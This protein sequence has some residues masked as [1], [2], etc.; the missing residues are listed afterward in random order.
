MTW[1]RILGLFVLFLITG[2][3]CDDHDFVPL[4][5]ADPGGAAGAPAATAVSLELTPPELSLAAGTSAEV[6]ATLVS[7]DGTTS[8]ATSNASWTSSEPAV[9][10]VD[11][12]TVV[13]VKKGSAEITVSS[14]G[15]TS[16]L[17]VT[18]TDAALVT[19]SITPQSPS[20]AKGLEKQLT[21]TGVFT[22]HTTQ[23]LTKQVT[24]SSDA[25]KVATVN[26]KGLLSALSVG[27]SKISAKLGATSAVTVAKVSPAT[28]ASIELTPPGPSIP[29]GLTQALTATATLSDGTTQ[30]VTSQSEWTSN[31]DTV[32]TV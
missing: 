2:V 8:D 9:A 32:A 7:S 1:L 25:K 20:L 14:S 19:L 10:T 28:V 31:D 6:K 16:T 18:V 29:K 23:D 26:A 24:W 5:P 27:S 4:R 11:G 17:T 15:V 30:D 3:G 12:G 22:D 13:G 21:A